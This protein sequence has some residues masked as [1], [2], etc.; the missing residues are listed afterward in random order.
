MVASLAAL[1]VHSPAIAHQIERWSLRY[2]QMDC[3]NNQNCFGVLAVYRIMYSVIIFHAVLAVLQRVTKKAPSAR[4]SIY[5]GW[6]G[7]KIV[8][9][10]AL[11]I[12]MFFVSNKVILTLQPYNDGFATLFVITSAM[13]LVDFAHSAAEKCVD[14]WERDRSETWKALLVGWTL[15]LYALTITAL[16]LLYVYFCAP[17]C[18]WNRFVVIT[19]T[20]IFVVVTFLSVHPAVQDANPRSGLAQ[21]SIILAHSAY[22]IMTALAGR[23]DTKCNPLKTEGSHNFLFGLIGAIFTFGAIAYST[24]NAAAAKSSDTRFGYVQLQQDPITAQ[25]GPQA[26]LRVEAVRDAVNAGSLPQSYLDEQLNDD[27]DLVE[28][29]LDQNTMLR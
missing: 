11:T 13:M 26:Q 1:A 14:M 17:G 16:V 21:S 20:I 22:Q 29:E 5:N 12:S 7:L 2:V 6:W 8:A 3:A 10:I 27:A 9:H 28:H 4:S 18:G 15:T 23:K 19:S 25:P 24:S